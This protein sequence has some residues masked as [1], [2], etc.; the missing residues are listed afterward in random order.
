M[1][2]RDTAARLRYHAASWEPEVRLLGNI[3]AKELQDLAQA[4][5]DR[6]ASLEEIEAELAQQLGLDPTNVRQ[7]LIERDQAGTLEET[8]LVADWHQAYAWHL[9]NS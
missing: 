4:F 2:L 5:L 7:V 8:R 1:T 6:P 9:E 3:T